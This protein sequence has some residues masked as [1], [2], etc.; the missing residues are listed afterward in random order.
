MAR[1]STRRVVALAVG[2]VL[3]TLLLGGG[4][5][6]STLRERRTRLREA[7]GRLMRTADAVR[8]A[9]DESL[10]ELRRRED[11]RPFYLYHHYYS[12]PDVLAISDPV[13]VSPLAH[14]PTDARLV[15]HFQIQPSGAVRT[16]YPEDPDAA[17][18]ALPPLARR[19]RRLASEPAFAP[20]RRLARGDAASP[21]LGLDDLDDATVAAGAERAG[22]P[23]DP[24]V[25]LDMNRFGNRQAREIAAAQ[26]GD[27]RANARLL[28]RGRQVPR[29]SRRTVPWE[30]AETPQASSRRAGS[31][32]AGSP[33][34]APPEP[35]GTPDGA[36]LDDRVRREAE[37]DYTPMAFRV[38]G[39]DWLLHR[40]V[41]HEGVS[42]VQGVLLDRAH[43]VGAWIPSL[44]ERHAEPAPRPTV[45][46]AGEGACALRRPATTHLPGVELCFSEAAL[47]SATDGLDEELGYQVGALVALWLIALLAAVAIARATRRAE[48]LSR[49]KSAFVSAVSHELRTP[50]TT[51]RMH[52]EMLDEDLVDE[53]RRPKV[54]RELVRESVR[55]AR[56]VDNVLGLS[57]LEE[58]RRRVH[59]T[60]GDLA[61]HVREVVR[62][63]RRFVEERG[64][65]LEGP[66]PSAACPALF[67]P[68]AVEQIVV[69]LLDN[70][71]K[72]GGG[73]TKAIEV[74]VGTRDGRPTLAVRDRGPGIP[75]AERARVFERFHRVERE[76]TAHAPGT[77]IGLALVAELAAAHGGEASVHARDGGGLEVR[78]DLD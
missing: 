61:A 49:Q 31:Q 42:V 24:A 54:H 43:L 16:P 38:L 27:P 59:R 30:Q 50:L 68:Q 37:V 14:P 66:D 72:Y 64:F 28:E 4:W 51:L 73:A 29:Y 60:E 55:L 53:A 13:A 5:L 9:V 45:V 15:G 74:W 52:A 3:S 78:V 65:T 56:L 71:V 17:A 32:R 23:D 10:E 62:E 35:P 58:G 34:P 21:V 7:R 47:A 6:G 19:L 40:I 33:Q 57:K 20:I 70:A 75:E 8:G 41:S 25:L 26:A 1:S 18:E 2:L 63:Q 76:E 39:D 12:P 44:V 22:A 48:L 67:D 46:P 77:G 11:R 36:R 69:N